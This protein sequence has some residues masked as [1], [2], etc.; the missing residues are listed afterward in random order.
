MTGVANWND[1]CALRH[2]SWT[3]EEGRAG[4]GSSLIAHSP[5]P[6]PTM[7]EQVN[8]CERVSP[9]C[10]E[11]PLIATLGRNHSFGQA[12]TCFSLLSGSF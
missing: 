4:F 8:L 12:M 5:R 1:L 3:M 7:Q 2:L 9:K 10:K 6:V 11:L